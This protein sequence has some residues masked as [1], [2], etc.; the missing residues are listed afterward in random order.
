MT[1]QLRSV[2]YGVTVTLALVVVAS[3][4][5]SSQTL[6]LAGQTIQPVFEGWEKN[7]DGTFTMFFGYLNRNYEEEPHIAIGPNNSFEPGPADRGQPTHYYPRRQSFVFGVTVPADWGKKDLVWTVNHN[8][9]ALTALGTL[10]PHWVLDEGVWR[11]NRGSGL[12]G[13]TSGEYV[14]KHAP[15]IK[16]VGDDQRTVTLGEPV[17]LTVSVADDGRPGPRPPRPRSGA[18]ASAATDTSLLVPLP[19]IG[20]ARSNAGVGTGGPVDQNMVKVRAAFETGLA[21]TW[22]HHRGPGKVTFAPM[23]IPVKPEEGKAT[24]TVRFSEPGTHVIRAVADDST[25]TTPADV[26]VVV[27]DASPEVRR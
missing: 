4:S 19:T 6:F 10:L 3:N 16:V 13:R 25:Y 27:K 14:P 15:S 5:A 12:G 2:L 7:P 22:L 21:V 17:T 20:G 11:A 9:R 8:G 1:S 24:T 18:S 23:V 26:T